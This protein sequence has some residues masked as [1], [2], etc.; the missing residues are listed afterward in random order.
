MESPE[1]NIIGTTGAGTRPRTNYNSTVANQFPALRLIAEH[2]LQIFGFSKL[3]SYQEV[4]AQTVLSGRDALICAPTGG[5][6]SLCYLLPA[7]ILPGLTLVVSPLIALMR[8]Q[9]AQCIKLGIP[10]RLL[11]SL[12]GDEDRASESGGLM[13]LRENV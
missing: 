13:A 6:K 5:G 7:T 1:Q 3:H 2:A 12:Q 10:C 8:D 11:D 4:A 9:L